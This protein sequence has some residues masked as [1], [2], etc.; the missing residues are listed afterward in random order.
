MAIHAAAAGGFDAGAE[1]YAVGRPTY[2]RG[3]A[4]LLARLLPARATVADVA[5][6]TG[7]WTR[8]LVAPGRTVV[9]VEPVRGM[10]EVLRRE[11]AGARVVSATAEALPVRDGALDAVTVAAAIHWF[12]LDEAVPELRR[13][14]RAGG[15]LAVLRN[16]R[17]ASVP[18]VAELDS[19]VNA[20]RTET[21]DSRTVPWRERLVAEPE[22]DEVEQAA[23]A[24]PEPFDRTK[25]HARVRSLSFVTGLP[26]RAQK[27]LTAQVDRLADGLPATFTMPYTTEV[28]VLRRA[29]PPRDP[30]DL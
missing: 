14:L 30:E 21:P 23:F 13:V 15:Y 19:I 24:N 12:R 22:L 18:W 9:A 7:K 8:Y 1:D 27:Q 10:R 20:H 11:V 3:A 25:L 4:A 17:D 5:A 16:V 26:V 2:A 29:I 6:G 28:V